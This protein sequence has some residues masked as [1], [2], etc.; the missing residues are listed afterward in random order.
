VQCIE[1][2]EVR[3]WITS[4]IGLV[5]DFVSAWENWKCKHV[6]VLSGVWQTKWFFAIYHTSRVSHCVI[7][8]FFCG[9]S[10]AERQ[11]VVVAFCLINSSLQ[12]IELNYMNIKQYILNQFPIKCPILI[13]VSAVK[14]FCLL[15]VILCCFLQLFQDQR[16]LPVETFLA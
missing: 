8:N 4:S 5:S 2:F 11:C 9:W 1:G 6:N 7:L 3:K 10:P 13:L 12:K 16:K 15:G 14:Q